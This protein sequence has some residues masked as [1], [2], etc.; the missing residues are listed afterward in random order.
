MINRIVR[1]VGVKQFD[2]YYEEL[3]VTP[4]KLI[5]RPDNL[6]IC[7]ADLRYYTG[8][9]NKAALKK[10]LPLSLHTRNHTLVFRCR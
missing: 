5:V 9:R 6:S 4:E 3:Q 10:K 2:M 1:L 8:Q 7:A